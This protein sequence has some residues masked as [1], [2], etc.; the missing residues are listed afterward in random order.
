MATIRIR[1]RAVI[2]GFL[3]GTFVL[4]SAGAVAAGPS[5]TGG[6]RCDRPFTSTLLETGGVRIYATPKE[7]MSQ[8]E[9]RE[10]AIAGRPVFACLKTSG[11]TRLLDLPE[12]SGAQHALWVEVDPEALAVRAPFVAYAFTEYYLDSHETWIRVRNLHTGADPRSCDAGGDIAP[13]RRP[14]IAKIVLGSNL[15]MA[16]TSTGFKGNVVRACG[17]AGTRLLDAGEGIDL[18]SLALDNGVLSWT[19]EGTEHDARL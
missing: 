3:I 19:D 9:H 6:R 13:G 8:P 11:E 17:P 5:S 12:E 16:W 15:A 1:R 18:E 10:P 7:S 4:G 2:V 14:D